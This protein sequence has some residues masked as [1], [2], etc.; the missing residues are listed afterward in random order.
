MLSVPHSPY[1]SLYVSRETFSGGTNLFHGKLRG[2]L[3][4]KANNEAHIT[5]ETIAHAVYKPDLHQMLF[6][7]KAL[8]KY[9]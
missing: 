3:D 1:T 5:A 4:F 7:L 8:F 6:N 2:V 9:P